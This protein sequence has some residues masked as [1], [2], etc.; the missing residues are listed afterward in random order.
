MLTMTVAGSEITSYF[1]YNNTLH[2]TSF[3]TVMLIVCL[4]CVPECKVYTLECHHTIP[5]GTKSV[6][7]MAHTLQ[8]LPRVGG[9]FLEKLGL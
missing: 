8:N 5:N 4:N 7:F 1:K 6:V 3:L 9:S 2:L